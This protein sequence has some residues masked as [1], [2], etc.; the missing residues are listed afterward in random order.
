LA[1]VALDLGAVA[2]DQ[3]AVAFERLDQ[4]QD[5]A[6]VVGVASRRLSSFSSTTM[7]PMPSCV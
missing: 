2:L 5:A 1:D 6:H 3:R 4:L 7:V